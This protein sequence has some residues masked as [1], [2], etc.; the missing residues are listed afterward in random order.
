MR[1]KVAA[2]LVVVA[3]LGLALTGQAAELREV[4][5]RLDLTLQPL[6]AGDVVHW[7]FDIGGY[8]LLALGPGW[9]VRASAGFDVLSVGPY[10]GI[11]LLRAVGSSLAVEGEALIQWTFG[12][13]T[14]VATAG[15]GARWVGGGDS[16]IVQLAA[17]PLNWTLSSIAGAPAMFM[18]SPSVTVGGGFAL[19]TGLEFGQAL[20][21]KFLAAPPGARAVLPMGG[22]MVSTRWT[23]LLGLAIAS[24]P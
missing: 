2:T 21:L 20:T 8:A 19:V 18:F 6:Y 23:S 11:G 16:L 9:G 5:L 10:V 14:P 13:S 12:V 3:L 24:T 4:G 1:A 22:W 17:F 15:V 7:N